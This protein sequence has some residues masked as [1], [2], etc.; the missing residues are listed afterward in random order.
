M[1]R[2]I[3]LLIRIIVILTAYVAA[4]LSATLFLAILIAGGFQPQS[5]VEIMG[6]SAGM[7]VSVPLM[8]SLIGYYSFLPSV[9]VIAIGELASR[10]DWLFYVLGAA[11]ISLL[12]MVWHWSNEPAT[13]LDS[14]I[15]SAAVAAG[16]VG[17]WVY[18]L[19][20]GRNAGKW[21]QSIASTSSG[22]S[23]S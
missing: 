1:I 23:G 5:D 4:L 16:I 19:I 22:S 13:I 14:G 6:L 10:R 18:W 17:G 21:H 12:V 9:I 15:A 3:S 2:F 8:S 20:A 7:I 11:L